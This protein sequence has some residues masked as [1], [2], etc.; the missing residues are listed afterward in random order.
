MGP[1]TAANQIVILAYTALAAI[2]CDPPS[3]LK[4]QQQPPIPMATVAPSIPMAQT[5]IAPLHTS[6][7]VQAGDNA[8]TPASHITQQQL[9]SAAGTYGDFTR[10]LQTLP[11]VVRNSDLSNEI[12]VRGGHPIENLYVLDG[13]EI[14]N[15]NHFA[16]AGSTG[17]FTS[18]IDTS[19]IGSVD[20]R[21]GV[22]DSSFSS[23]L[24]ALI[25]VQTRR[26]PEFAPKNQQT[27]DQATELTLGIS[28][29]GGF[30]QRALSPRST[31]LVSAHRSIVSLLTNNI[32]ID[33]VPTYSNA[34]TRIEW[35]PGPRDSLAFLTLSGRDSIAIHPCVGDYAATSLTNTHYSGW[36]TTEA[37]SWNHLFSAHWNSQLTASTSIT[38]QNIAQQ[39]QLGAV[40]VNG[41]PTCT[42][43][44]TQTTY[45]EHSKDGLSALNYQLQADLP[46][47]WNGW[48]LSSGASLKLQ[49][50]NDQV[51]QP[52][53]Q[54]SPFNPNPT[55]SDAIR[56]HRN[57]NAAQAAA[58]LQ[59]EGPVGTHLRLL[60]GL[61]A[62]TFAILNAHALD[63][64]ISLA[65][66]LTPNHPLH[67]SWNIS[68]QLPP[69]LDLLTYP[70]NHNLFPIQVRQQSAGLRLL[71]PTWGTLDAELYQKQYR[72][73]AVSTEYPQLALSNMIDTLGQSFV[74]LALTSAGIA[75]ARG[76]ELTLR[77]HAH[78]HLQLLTS[79]TY[80][81][82]TYKALD[83]IRRRGNYDYPLAI[84][85]MATLPLPR[86]FELDLR[87][88]YS[89]GRLYTPFDLPNSLAQNRGIFNLAQVNAQRGP[90]YNRLD[91]EL[92]K[93]IRIGKALLQIH[94]G[95]DNLFNRQNL[96]DYLWMPNCQF[97]PQC[98]SQGT[99]HHPRSPDGHLSRTLRPLHLLASKALTSQAKSPPRDRQNG[100]APPSALAFLSVIPEG[101]Q[102]L[103][104]LFWS[105]IPAGNLPPALAVLSVIP[106][107][108]LLPALAVLF[109]IPEGN[110]LLPLLFWSVIPA[111]NLLPALAVLSVIPK[112]NLL[113][114]LAVALAVLSVIPEGNL[115]PALAVLFVIP[116]GNLLLH[117][118]FPQPRSAVAPAVLSVIPKGN[119]LPAFAVALA[120]LSVIPKG[121]LLPAFAVAPAFLSVIPE[122]NLLF[123]E[124]S[125]RLFCVLTLAN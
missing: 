118:V 44:A 111:G 102:L 36:R 96:L 10:Y 3:Q 53:G 23:R 113:V 58:F 86:A 28:G 63:P 9:L 65:W 121:N 2:L 61:R 90:F 18:M 32:G 46:G 68:S 54:Q 109:V 116:E 125:I 119:L 70:L 84:N 104:L 106:E 97:S 31:L 93:P 24:S 81:R 67:F 76:L 110:L 5:P 124:R 85:T 59:A 120:V 80:S 26:L 43:I 66:R 117:E 101:N 69:T 22:Y 42:P 103:P 34:L 105:V 75:N 115:L 21:S 108:N 89:S 15:I 38:A 60:T 39:L 78:N 40:G 45:A 55:W 82:S 83:H 13:I 49:S 4:A 98:I 92:S 19:S 20:F 62:E 25:Q 51:Q 57:F 95:V 35:H 50:P 1:R 41:V 112:G 14:P 71:Q 7:E 47:R 30:Y 56:I 8:L 100:P 72:R 48:L 107:G 79:A 99:P 17:G 87:E 27:G 77:A 29:A 16:L 52:T 88:N 73:E 114:A 12:L 122:G 74:W 64:R 94:A 6:I 91:L 33:G 11:G 123:H 37:L